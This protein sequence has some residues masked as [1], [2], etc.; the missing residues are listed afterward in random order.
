MFFE[1]SLSNPKM[2]QNGAQMRLKME[3]K[4]SQNGTKIW[5]KFIFEIGV[6]SGWIEAGL[7]ESGWVSVR[8][9]AVSGYV[10]HVSPGLHLPP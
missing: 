7:A 8:G 6:K 3:P 2:I 4:W 9:L 1:G 10:W 5:W